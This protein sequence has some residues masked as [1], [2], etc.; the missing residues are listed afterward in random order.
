[1]LCY[2][3]M[4]FCS[5]HDKCKESPINNGKCPRALTKEVLDGAEKWWGKTGAPICAFSKK[6]DCFRL[7]KQKNGLVD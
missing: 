2:K 5:F 1:M 4:T 6:P 7:V 3:D